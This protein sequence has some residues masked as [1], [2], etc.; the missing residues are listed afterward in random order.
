MENEIIQQIVISLESWKDPEI[1][2]EEVRAMRDTILTA[3]RID[4]E[5]SLEALLDI[6]DSNDTDYEL[7]RSL[8]RI[9]IPLKIILLN[10]SE[11][12]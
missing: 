8:R 11:N 6:I 4:I 12:T 1:V 5:P 9:Y 3:I 7:G 10:D 2:G